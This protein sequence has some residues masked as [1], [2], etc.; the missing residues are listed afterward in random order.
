[1]PRDFYPAIGAE[2][3]DKF[4]KVVGV[5]QIDDVTVQ[6]TTIDFRPIIT[7]LVWAIVTVGTLLVATSCDD[8]GM[9]QGP[10]DDSPRYVR[11]V[12]P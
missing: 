7:F 5:E 9:Y 1:M 2:M 6:H 8:S 4:T 3:L 11:M 12:N 10:G